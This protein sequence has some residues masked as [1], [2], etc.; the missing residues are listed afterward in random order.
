MAE[1][2]ENVRDLAQQ[3]GMQGKSDQAATLRKLD[4]RQRKTLTLFRETETITSFDVA[5]AL[6][7]K[8]RTARLLCQKWAEQGFLSVRD[9]AKKSRKYALSEQFA[10]LVK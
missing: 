4:A 10:G 7:L 6:S 8:P 9:P 5:E 3:A 2:F 1:A